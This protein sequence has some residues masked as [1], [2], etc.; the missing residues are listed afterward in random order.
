M[1]TYFLTALQPDP[2]VAWYYLKFLEEGVL[3]VADHVLLF[4]SAGEAARRNLPN[5]VWLKEV[6]DF[7]HQKF[8]D[9]PQVH[10]YEQGFASLKDI[11][12]SGG[13]VTHFDAMDYMFGDVPAGSITVSYDSDVFWWD[14]ERLKYYVG[15][16]ELDKF[17]LVGGVPSGC[18]TQIHDAISTRR[19]PDNVHPSFVVI[20]TDNMM[21]VR[22]QPGVMAFGRPVR[23]RPY[24]WK[25]G[26][27]VDQVDLHVT[28]RTAVDVFGWAS[29]E[30]FDR[31]KLNRFYEVIDQPR[32]QEAF[33]TFIGERGWCHLAATSSQMYIWRTLFPGLEEDSPKWTRRRAIFAVARQLIGFSRLLK[34]KEFMALPHAKDCINEA[35]DGLEYTCGVHHIEREDIRKMKD[36]IL[37][38][39]PL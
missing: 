37:E 6:R 14:I 31:L 1:D 28:E 23:W 21:K 35:Q 36:R 5:C 2:V 10:W 29:L 20:G 32:Y 38:H 13:F 8:L 16:V 4:W 12:F 27:Y 7:F 26:D 15:L 22:P 19:P 25:A 18:G 9:I 24:I 33:D 17:D 30:I 3:D 34:D 11:K 39:Y